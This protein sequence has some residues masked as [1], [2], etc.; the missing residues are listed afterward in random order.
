MRFIGTPT[1]A[2]KSSLGYRGWARLAQWRLPDIS[3]SAVTMSRSYGLARRNGCSGTSR[4]LFR[5][6]TRDACG[7]LGFPGFFTPQ[8]KHQNRISIVSKN[9]NFPERPKKTRETRETH[10]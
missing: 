3:R 9:L 10:N 8:P 1:V 2:A 5:L 4:L 6:M 7:F